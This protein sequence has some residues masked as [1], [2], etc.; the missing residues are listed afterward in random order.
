M[1]DS[2]PNY[3]ILVNWG[4]GKTR[5]FG[6]SKSCDYCNWRGWDGLPY[7]G[8]TTEQVAAFI[9]SCK[10][11]TISISG[12][13]EPLYRLNENLPKLLAM[14]G[15][16]RDHGFRTRV[17]TREVQHVAML[18]G[19]VDYFS[20]SLDGDVLAELPRYQ[21]EWSGMD[22]IV[23]S[24]LP[25]NLKI[26]CV[27]NVLDAIPRT[28]CKTPV[29]LRSLRLKY[30]VSKSNPLRM[31]ISRIAIKHSGKLWKPCM[32]DFPASTDGKW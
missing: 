13:A 23:T 15:V 2:Q 12:G 17:V 24:A 3:T 1:H 6:C 18:R 11:S 29:V 30:P 19:I 22:V 31:S 8:Q 14:V 25:I 26:N 20:I 27:R 5:G 16:I 32:K 10:K 28:V 21:H 9:A 4:V 7:Q